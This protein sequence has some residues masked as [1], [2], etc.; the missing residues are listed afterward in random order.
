[1]EILQAI[2]ACTA[3]LFI[4]LILSLIMSLGITERS[5]ASLYEPFYYNLIMAALNAVK[6]F[7]AG[8]LSTILARSIA[9][10]GSF[11]TS[12]LVLLALLLGGLRAAM[13]REEGIHPRFGAVSALISAVL[14]YCS[15]V[16][17]SRIH[18]A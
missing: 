11:T 3:F 12:T 1:M 13:G 15:I 10:I 16:L 14:V 5:V 8:L 4:R 18:L 9:D 2:I 7:I 6:S 17:G